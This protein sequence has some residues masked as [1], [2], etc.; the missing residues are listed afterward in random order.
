MAPRSNAGSRSDPRLWGAGGARVRN[1]PAEQPDAGAWRLILLAAGR[2]P[3]VFD[4]G[5]KSAAPL[6]HWQAVSE[7]T[8]SPAAWLSVQ[9]KLPEN[10]ASEWQNGFSRRISNAL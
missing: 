6:M 5:Q 8:V 9:L 3:P 4:G 7:R 2:W 1:Y 10:E